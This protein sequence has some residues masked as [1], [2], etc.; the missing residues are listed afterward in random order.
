[1][2]ISLQTP[3]DKRVRPTPH[4]LAQRVQ[5]AA[6]GD[7]AAQAPVFGAV[8]RTSFAAPWAMHR[9]F[10]VTYKNRSGLHMDPT[11]TVAASSATLDI[12]AIGRAQDLHIN[13]K[14]LPEKHRIAPFAADFPVE[15]LEPLSQ[16]S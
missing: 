15:L 5:V 13:L 4:V 11:Q 9:V 10:D 1:M 16:V 7:T 8:Q 14:W 3:S 6:Q 12:M 2:S